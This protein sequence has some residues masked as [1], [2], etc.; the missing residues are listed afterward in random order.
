MPLPEL[1]ESE[2]LPPEPPE[3]LFAESPALVAPPPVA[4][5]EL[6]PELSEEPDAEPP[7]FSVAAEVA[8]LS[9]DPEDGR[10]SVL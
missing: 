1:P 2:L 7:L 10:L 4:V 8:A 5:E 9:P 3:L 6:D